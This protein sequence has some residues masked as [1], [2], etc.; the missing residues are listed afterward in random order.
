MQRAGGRPLNFQ[1]GS[2]SPLQF[3]DRLQIYLSRWNGLG[4]SKGEALVV[5]IYGSGEDLWVDDG[6]LRM[7]L[8]SSPDWSA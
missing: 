3:V 4:C 5:L 2:E 7:H 1:D 8:V 6:N